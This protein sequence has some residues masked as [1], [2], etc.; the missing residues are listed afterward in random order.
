MTVYDP[1]AMEN[2]RRAL[3][4]AGAT[5]TSALEA[6]RDADLVLLLTEW[7]EF[8]E[9]DPAALGAVVARRADRRRPQRPRPGAVARGRLDLPRARPPLR[10]P[11]AHCL[12]GRVQ[13]WAGPAGLPRS[14]PAEGPTGLSGAGRGYE[15]GVD[16]EAGRPAAGCPKRMVHGPCGGVGRT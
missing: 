2:A 15:G 12:S 7:A 1:E 10:L 4:G 9:M 11:R 14:D 16:V 13:G 3:P 8:R 5:P 6:A